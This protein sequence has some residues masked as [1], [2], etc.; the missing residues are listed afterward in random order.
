MLTVQNGIVY[1]S[2]SVV[3]V[4]TQAD[5]VLEQKRNH[6]HTLAA[7]T[8]SASTITSSSRARTSRE[9]E[10]SALS[11]DFDALDEEGGGDS[12]EQLTD[13]TLISIRANEILA[14]VWMEFNARMISKST[15]KSEFYETNMDMATAL[16]AKE[17]QQD[18][19]RRKK[20]EVQFSAIIT[21]YLFMELIIE[22]N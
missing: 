16:A 17:L 11:V 21:L 15:S 13:E 20:I 9:K 3:D 1:I 19:D 18:R 10:D 8:T 7:I 12:A 6:N 22:L 14:N 2:K 4:S 5:E